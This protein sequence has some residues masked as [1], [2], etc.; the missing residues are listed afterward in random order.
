MPTVAAISAPSLKH[1]GYDAVFFT[2]ISKKPVYLLIE[3][4]KAQLKDADGLCGQ[5]FRSRR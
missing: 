3:D 4:G 2:G 1:A 5:R